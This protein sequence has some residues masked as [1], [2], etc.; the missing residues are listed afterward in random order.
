M[1]IEKIRQRRRKEKTRGKKYFHFFFSKNHQVIKWMKLLFLES[2]YEIEHNGKLYKL[3]T[4]AKTL[5]ELERDIRSKIKQDNGD[6]I[7]EFNEN[8]KMY[9]LDDIEDLEEGM[10]IRVSISTQ[11]NSSGFLLFFLSLSLLKLIN[12]KLKNNKR[13]QLN[14]FHSKIGMTSFL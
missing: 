6:L 11:P 4:T 2:S 1:P 8:G 10:T 9:I 5:L 14:I 7:L 12:L 3:K 13:N